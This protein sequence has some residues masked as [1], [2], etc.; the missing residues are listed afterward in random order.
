MHRS[1]NTPPPQATVNAST[2][3]PNQSSPR[4]RAATAPLS[5]KAKVPARSRKVNS[6]WPFSTCV[7]AW[8]FTREARS[9][10]AHVAARRVGRRQ[11]FLS[12][13][14]DRVAGGEGLV[15]RL[16]EQIVVGRRRRGLVA[17][18]GLGHGGP[19]LVGGAVQAA[20][21]GGRV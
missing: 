10:V 13:R 18:G 1:R 7:R 20:G 12:R 2:S 6:T 4:S 11:L 9:L 8:A 19:R 14:L 15:Q 16:V 5:A 17:G 3:T 21:V